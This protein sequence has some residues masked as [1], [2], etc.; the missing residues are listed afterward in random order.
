MSEGRG[1]GHTGPHTL[2]RTEA[3]ELYCVTPGREWVHLRFHTES[4]IFVM[5]ENASLNIDL[6][7]TYA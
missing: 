2:D 1:T 5:L 3:F 4:G 7:N 6:D